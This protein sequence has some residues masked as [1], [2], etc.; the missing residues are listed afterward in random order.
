MERIEEQIIEVPTLHVIPQEP[1]SERIVEQ[2]VEVP[3]LHDIPRKPTSKRIVE[4]N[5]EVPRLHDI[6]RK[7]ISKQIVEQNVDDPG[8]QDI[9]QE[10][11]SSSAAVPLDTA[12]WLGDR[13]FRTF[14]PDK[15]SA[16]S[17]RQSSANMLSHS[18]PWTPEAYEAEQRKIRVEEWE[19]EY[20]TSLLG[21]H[22][23]GRTLG[24]EFG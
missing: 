4:Q 17:T 18:S 14:S 5:V 13:G 20:L 22:W 10:R 3:K 7:R 1:I 23:R 21:K 24:G 16:K 9:P 19:E 12:E 6:P 2:I 11:T 15:K 8:L